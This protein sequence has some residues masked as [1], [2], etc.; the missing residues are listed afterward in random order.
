MSVQK[1]WVQWNNLYAVEKLNIISCLIFDATCF[2]LHGHQQVFTVLMLKAA[3][4]MFAYEWLLSTSEQQRRE[5]TNVMSLSHTQKI[6]PKIS[7]KKDRFNNDPMVSEVNTSDLRIHRSITTL[8]FS[9]IVVDVENVCTIVKGKC[10]IGRSR[11]SC[12]SKA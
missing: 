5:Q 7:Q 3:H 9:E 4:I 12:R 2:I 8:P 11:W 10:H 1:C 6:L